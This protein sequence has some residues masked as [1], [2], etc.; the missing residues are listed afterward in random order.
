M[1]QKQCGVAILNTNNISAVS[2]QHYV[3]GR[4]TVLQCAV[5]RRMDGWMD[6]WMD[7]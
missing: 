2:L 4:L 6:D 5:S 7:E 1:L 3:A